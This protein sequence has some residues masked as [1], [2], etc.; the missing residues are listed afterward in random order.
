MNEKN[1]LPADFN[2]VFPFT[3]WSNEDFTAK[4]NSVEYTYPKEKTSPMIIGNAT[5]EEVQN[6]RKKFARELG[7]RE[8]YKTEKFKKMDVHVP[9]GTP[10]I[11]TDSDLTPLIQ[12]CLEP[13]AIVS[14]KVAKSKKFDVEELLSKDEEGKNVSSVLN[15]NDSLL[16]GT[17]GV[18][19]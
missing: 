17:A 10:A 18:I 13:L 16:K 12:K 6:I 19:A 14:A 4:W 7:I 1:V 3:N 8:F 2:G 9:G 15:K 5:P 11:Y